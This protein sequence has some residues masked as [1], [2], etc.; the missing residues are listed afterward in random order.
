MKAPLAL[1]VLWH[2]EFNDGETY[3]N[4]IFSEF[5][6]NV[7][8]PLSRGM[9]IPVYYRYVS[10]LK[11]IP[12]KEYDFTVIVAFIDANFR[13][14][15]EYTSYLSELSNERSGNI[16]VIPFAIER[17]DLRLDLGLKNFGRLYE[18]QDKSEYIISILAHETVRHLYALREVSDSHMFAPPPPL[19]LFISHAKAD[20]VEIATQIK[21]FVERSLPLKTFFDAND[22]AIGYDFSE[23]IK[24]YIQD[25]VII[26][27]HTDMYSSREW[28]RREI[29]LAKENNRPIVVLNCFQNGESRS[30][31]YMA[32]VLTVHFQNID[33]EM[34]TNSPVWTRLITAVLKETL[35]L[36]YQGLWLKY[37]IRKNRMKGV[38]A[39]S[40]S[41]YPP[42]L[43]TVLRKKGKINNLFIYPD[44]PL[45]SEELSILKL[46][47][48]KIKFLTPSEL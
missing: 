16:L 22:I 17:N 6:R 43:V 45:G 39:Q 4:L 9:N 15:D 12:L 11:A 25:A 3:A 32:N 14:D 18:R 48:P 41:D 40:I 34:H 19:K 20:G 5:R 23:E 47:D 2:P 44:P 36:R 10:P 30:F 35:R 31:P 1:F 38:I 37:I 7:R 42:E 24:T 13:L 21:A 29:L 8:D 33:A 26:A 46:I 28:C 27:I